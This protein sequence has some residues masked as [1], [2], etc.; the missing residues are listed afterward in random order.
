MRAALRP[1]AAILALLSFI[2]SPAVAHDHRPPEVVLRHGDLEQRGRLVALRWTRP[3]GE[4]GCA[5][6]LIVK[7]PSYPGQGLPVRNGEFRARL[8][9]IKPARPLSVKAEARPEVGADGDLAGPAADVGLRLR[10]RRPGGDLAAWTALL[11]SRVQDHLYLRVSAR[12]KDGDGCDDRQKAT[13]TFH[14]S[15]V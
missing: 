5:S 7:K 3:A 13:W 4:E 10:P 12:W 2:P 8:R 9:F 6:T 14:V 15:A 11:H 1:A